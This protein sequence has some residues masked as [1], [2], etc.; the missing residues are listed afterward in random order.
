MTDADPNSEQAEFWNGPSGLKWIENE[1]G[2]DAI[3]SVVSAGLLDRG[4]I[5]PGERVLEVGCGTGAN[6]LLLAEAVGPKGE[7]LALDISEPLLARA[8]ARRDAAG[9]TQPEFRLADA[10]T[11]ALPKAHFDLLISRFGVMFFADP[12]AAFA[13]MRTALA[14][15][16][17]LVFACW[18]GIEGNPWFR[19]PRDVAA[20]RLGWPDPPEHGAPGPMAFADSGRVTGLMAQAGFA[21]PQAKEVT[22]ELHHPGG[23]PA[24]ATLASRVGLAARILK[25]FDGTDADAAAIRAGIEAAFADFAAPDGARIPARVIFYTARAE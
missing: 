4:A 25:D 23:I 6:S 17:R 16:G 18:A 21:D 5:R 13:N 24:A 8:A 9:L 12:Q 19:L 10:Q 2:M 3:L 7:V 20:N 15:G 22:L 14:R 11:A 1:E